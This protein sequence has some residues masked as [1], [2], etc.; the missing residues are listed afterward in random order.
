VPRVR[1]DSH[2]RSNGSAAA[3]CGAGKGVVEV[4]SLCPKIIVLVDFCDSR[5]T[6]RFIGKNCENIICFAITCFVI[7]Y[8]L[9]IS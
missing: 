2:T 4:Y 9:S 7:I 5:L 3:R 6:I 1:L 8:I